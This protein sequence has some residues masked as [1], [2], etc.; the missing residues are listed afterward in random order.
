VRLSGASESELPA[1]PA[2]QAELQPR[3]VPRW[4]VILVLLVAAVWLGRR[5]VEILAARDPARQARYFLD[6]HSHTMVLVAACAAAWPALRMYNKGKARRLSYLAVCA[7]VVVLLNPIFVDIAF[8]AVGVRGYST[9]G[10][11]LV[12]TA[13]VAIGLGLAAAWRV[14]RSLTALTG[15]ALPPAAAFVALIGVVVA[16]LI[17]VVVL[18]FMSEFAGMSGH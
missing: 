7:A 13:V 10:Q 1:A 11:D 5:V 15:G 14:R 12:N 9:D 17:L 2:A 18:I 3:R 4:P 8:R 16:V 6:A